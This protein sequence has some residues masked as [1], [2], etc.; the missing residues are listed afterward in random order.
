MALDMD[1]LRRFLTK[2]KEDNICFHGLELSA[3]FE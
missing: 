1:V 2:R 3:K